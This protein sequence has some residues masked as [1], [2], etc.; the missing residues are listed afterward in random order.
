MT[1]ANPIQRRAWTI[2]DLDDLPDGRFEIARGDL[3]VNPPPAFRHIGATA[4]LCRLL[5]RYAPADLLVTDAGLGVEFSDLPGDAT[6]YVPD[7]V[8]VDADVVERDGNRL[9]PRE[10][11]LAVE[12]LSPSNAS[13]DLVLKRNDYAAGGIPQYWIVDQKKRTLT[14]L[15]LVGAL[16]KETVT[17]R[18]G[19]V[20]TSDLPFPLT[21]DPAE[22]V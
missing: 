9:A 16:Y 13:N 20:W 1:A 19:E 3:I 21:L 10:V 14:V 22:F 17:I 15:E 12:V 7:I 5:D 6:Y 4:R 8:V 18:P 11:L 2:E